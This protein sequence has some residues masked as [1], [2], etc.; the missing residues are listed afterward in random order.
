MNKLEGAYPSRF[1]SEVGKGLL[2]HIAR[3]RGARGSERRWEVDQ[4]AIIQRR[5]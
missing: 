5:G 4:T 1:G 3:G 2:G